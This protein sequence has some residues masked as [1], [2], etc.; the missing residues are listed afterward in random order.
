MSERMRVSV[1]RRVV[2]RAVSSVLSSEDVDDDNMGFMIYDKN[3]ERVREAPRTRT[4]R[5]RMGAL[6][7]PVTL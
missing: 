3:E 4:S 7:F 6:R 5:M 2:W 1:M